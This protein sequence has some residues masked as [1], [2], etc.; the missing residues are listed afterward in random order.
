MAKIESN[1]FNSIKVRLELEDGTEVPMLEEFQFHKGTIRTFLCGSFDLVVYLF[2]FHKGT[3]RT[4]KG[5]SP[6]S[7]FAPFQFHKG[8][9]RTQKICQD[10]FRNSQIS[11]P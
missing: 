1:N 3:I 8:T 11:I 9:I 6:G 10:Y 4:R 7:Y 2:Q 5:H